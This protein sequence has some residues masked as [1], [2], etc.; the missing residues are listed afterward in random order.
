MG[1]KDEFNAALGLSPQHWQQTRLCLPIGPRLWTDLQHSRVL[2]I[3][4][5]IVFNVL[6]IEFVELLEIDISS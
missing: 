4:I 2:I 1:L 6:I 3:S 5:L